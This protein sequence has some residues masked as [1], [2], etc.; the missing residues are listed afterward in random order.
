MANSFEEDAVD[1]PFED[2]PKKGFWESI[3]MAAAASLFF[4]AWGVYVNWAYG[5][6]AVVQVG[7]TQG[8]IS[9]ISTFVSAEVLRRMYIALKR[10]GANG[11]LTV[12]LGLAIIN[13][14]VFCAHFVAGTPEIWMTMMPGAIISVFFCSGYTY[15]L[16]LAR[17]KLEQ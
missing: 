17:I 10:V 3:L 8:L 5:Y 2:E 12:P 15:R 9:F 16:R 1:A 14:S 6:G 4:I 11:A 7:I 13:G